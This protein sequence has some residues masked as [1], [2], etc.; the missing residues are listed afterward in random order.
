MATRK[1]PINLRLISFSFPI[2]AIVSVLHRASGFWLFLM[3]PIML[4]GLQASLASEDSFW[5]VIHA[6]KT[7]PGVGLLAV[8]MVF[9]LYHFVA[10]FRHMGVDLHWFE[11]KVAGKFSAWVVLGFSLFIS[12]V[13]GLI[14]LW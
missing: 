11:S 5:S 12:L 13:A 2:T 1:R 6:L 10:G 8:S 4:W 3:V 7:F 9:F 14:W